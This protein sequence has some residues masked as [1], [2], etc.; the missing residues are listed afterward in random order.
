[1]KKLSEI[2]NQG[3]RE[4]WN[5][6]KPLTQIQHRNLVKL[7]GYCREGSQMLLVYEYLQ[8]GSLDKFLSGE[9]IPLNYV[10]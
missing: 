3:W 1:M 6:V 7:R 9:F 10:I 5:E 4:F 2:S 8:N